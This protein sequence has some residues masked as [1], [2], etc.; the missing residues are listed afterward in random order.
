VKKQNHAQPRATNKT[1]TPPKKCDYSAPYLCYQNQE[2]K[3]WQIAQGCCNHWDC[4]RCGEIRA[5]EEYARMV[6]GAEAIEGEGRKLYFWTMTCRGK[7][8]SRT[9]AEGGYLK[10]TD[11]LLT[12]SRNKANRAGEYWCYVQVTERQ[13]RGHPHSHMIATYAPPDCEP[14]A[15]GDI[16]PDGSRARHDLLWS[17]WFIAANLRAGLGSQC[18]ISEVQSAAAVGRYVAKYLFKQTALDTWPKGWKRIRYSQNWPQ[19]PERKNNTA[20]PV[21]KFADWFRVWD[22]GEPVRADSVYTYAAAQARGIT[23]VVQPQW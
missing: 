17:N 7:T 20:F 11:K 23:N 16:L 19:L 5:K 6:N 15:K 8:L 9:E 13:K 4:G 3:I 14:Y 18:Q 12:A 2:T 21:I 1:Y 10:W 22:I